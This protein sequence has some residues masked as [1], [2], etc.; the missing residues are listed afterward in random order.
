V[1]CVFGEVLRCATIRLCV[2]SRARYSF[3]N[4]NH[5]RMGNNG[6]F[7]ENVQ[8]KETEELFENDSVIR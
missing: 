4:Y 5:Q 1:V 6:K 8:V 3:L 7:I 2:P